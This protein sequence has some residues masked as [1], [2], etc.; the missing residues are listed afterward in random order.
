VAKITLEKEEE[1]EGGKRGRKEREGRGEGEGG[2]RGEKGKEGKRPYNDNKGQDNHDF[3]I[4]PPHRALQ[5]VGSFLKFK[6]ILVQVFCFVDQQFNTLP[7]LQY[8]L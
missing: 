6:C 3:S 7:S 1:S 2:R 4:L 5:L 8:L